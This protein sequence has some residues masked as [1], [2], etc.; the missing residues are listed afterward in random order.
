MTKKTPRH[1]LVMFD[2]DGTLIDSGRDIC[3]AVN[4]MRK[5]YGLAP[6]PCPTVIGYVG[7]G[8]RQ[9]V[10]RSLRR[11]AVDLEEATRVCAR[12]YRAHLHDRTTLYP[13]VRDGLRRL[14]RAGYRLAV[15]SNKPR[16]A[17][18][19]IL[20]HFRIAPLFSVVLGGGDTQR[21]KPH[22]EPLR[23]ALRQT[24]T[25]AKR[26]WMVGDHKTDLEAARRAH[27]RSIFL[28]HGLGVRGGLQPTRVFRSFRTMADFL[29]SEA[30]RS[31]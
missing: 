25:D 20:R 11:H 19:K 31:R 1:P 7:D 29:V 3:T 15:I 27:V 26:S 30:A 24:R 21:L 9:L 8:I 18:R 6:L 4:L 12:H 10:K 22:P 5:D 14:R 17:C 23:A 16:A 13:G 2:L 28:P